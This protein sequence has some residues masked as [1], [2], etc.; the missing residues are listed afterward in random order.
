MEL[1][2]GRGAQPLL[3]AKTSYTAG[4]RAAQRK[5]RVPALWVKDT[6]SRAAEE[7]VTQSI[8]RTSPAGTKQ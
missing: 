7:H 2:T 6:K 5:N 4:Q 3:R 8:C 1:R